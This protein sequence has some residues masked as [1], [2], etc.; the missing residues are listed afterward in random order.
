[1]TREEF[2]KLVAEEFP[3]AIPE[4]FR[5][6]VEN[7]AFLVEDEPSEEV[8]REEGLADN[9]TLLGL[10]RGIPHTARGDYYGVGNV[11]P[12]T[13]TLYQWPI[14][15]EAEAMLQENDAQRVHDFSAEKSL[16]PRADAL[17]S[18][19]DY[20]F[21]SAVRWVIRETIWHEVAHHFGMNEHEVRE[22]EDERDRE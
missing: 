5:A 12:D 1:M 10:Y 6:K 22:R 21:L 18:P 15:D 2:E 16:G 20:H 17:R 7:V 13:I 8:R 19:S 14:E 9:E 3:D 4:K 11:L